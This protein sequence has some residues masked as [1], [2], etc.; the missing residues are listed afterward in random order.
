M[1]GPKANPASAPATGKHAAASGSTKP[2]PPPPPPPAVKL[3][4][5]RGRYGNISTDGLPAPAVSRNTSGWSGAEPSRWG[6]EGGKA[7]Q[8]N[9]TIH[10]FTAE[11]YRPPWNVAMRLAHWAC[12]PAATSGEPCHRVSTL[13]TSSNDTSGADPLASL[14]EPV[15]V[16]DPAAELWS[17]F[18]AGYH[19]WCNNA[20]D[21]TCAPVI[22]RGNVNGISLATFIPLGCADRV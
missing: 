14:W 3:E 11:M 17:L 12:D 21:I 5:L 10:V 4:Y 16:Y 13:R 22:Y 1:Q 20:V 7:V 18:C 9:G 8:I 19:S 15:P 2:L 6:F